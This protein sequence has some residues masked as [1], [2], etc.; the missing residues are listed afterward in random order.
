[1]E[2]ITTTHGSNAGSGLTAKFIKNSLPPLDFYSHELPGVT[3]TK[4]G[5]NDGGLCPF[6]ADNNAGSFHVNIVTGA[7]IC[8][9]CDISGGDIIAFTMALYGLNFGEALHKLADDWGLS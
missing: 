8:F 1:M 9:A 6:H 2:V 4:H 3:L 5:W 7:F